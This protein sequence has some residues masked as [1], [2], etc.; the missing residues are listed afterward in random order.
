MNKDQVKGRVKEAT[1]KAQKNMGQM[2]KDRSQQLKG[3]AKEMEGKAQKNL[4][5]IKHKAGK[6]IDR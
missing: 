4:G 1:G 5:D 2:T 6:A 3:A